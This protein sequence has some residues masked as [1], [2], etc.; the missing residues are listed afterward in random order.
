MDKQ[1]QLLPLFLNLG[2]NLLLKDNAQD[3][4]S[5]IVAMAAVFSQHDFDEEKAFAS[6]PSKKIVRD[7]VS[8]A[9]SVMQLDTLEV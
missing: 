2:T 1:L 7:F 9:L 8:L 6:N 3:T 4:L 5:I